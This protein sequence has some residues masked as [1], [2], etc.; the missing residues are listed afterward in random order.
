MRVGDIASAIG[1]GLVAGAVGTVAI[2][3]SEMIGNK[4]RGEEPS[5]TPAEATQKVLD[6]EPRNEQAKKRLTNVAHFGYGTAWGVPRGL[7]GLVGLSAIP[8]TLVHF[9]AVQAVAMTMLPALDVAPPPTEW[10]RK[11]LGLE[12]FHHLL[13]AAAATLAFAFLDRRSER[14]RLQT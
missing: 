13:Y 7:L 11:E 10:D 2:T 5:D 12:A 6:V 8:A 3:A 1:K 9:A 14:A 4:V